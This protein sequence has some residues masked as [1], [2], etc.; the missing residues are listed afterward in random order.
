MPETSDEP[1]SD[2][3]VQK[4]KSWKLWTQE[5][6]EADSDEGD[7]W[8]DDVLPEM[9]TF[10]ASTNLQSGFQGT[11][12]IDFEGIAAMSH[13]G[14]GYTVTEED[15]ITSSYNVTTGETT[16]SLIQERSN[17]T[18]QQLVEN[19]TAVV[20]AKK[21]ELV[22][23]S[24]LGCFQRFPRNRARNLVDVRWV[25]TWKQDLKKEMQIKA[26]MT[27]R[28]FKDQAQGLETFAGTASRWG[29][30]VV[31]AVTAQEEE[32]TLF[33]FDVSLAFAKGLSFKELSEL[34]GE[35]L[36]VVQFELSR[37]DAKILQKIAGFEAF[38]AE[39]EVLLMVKAVYGLKDAPRA[40]RK[41]LHLLLSTFDLVSLY[42]D[43]QL[44]TRHEKNQLQMILSAHVDDLKGGAPKKLALKLLSH[45][46]A[47]IGT[48]KQQWEN[49][50]HVGIEHERVPE[51][52]WTHQTSYAM[53]LKEIDR[54]MFKSVGENDQVSDEASNAFSSLL[55]GVAWLCL[56][57]AAIAIYVQS[58]QRHGQAPRGCDM[59]RL[60]LVVR[61]VKKHKTGIMFKR[62]KGPLRLVVVSDAAFKSIPDES[63][64][65]ALRGAVII[66]CSSS[67][68]SP[69]SPD[70]TCCMIEYLCKRQRRVV[71]STFSGELNALIDAIELLLVLQI[72]FHQV[73]SGTTATA[74]D[75]AKLLDEGGLQPPCEAVIDARSVFD[76]LAAT[77]VGDLV[78]GSLKLHVLSIRERLATQALRCLWWSDTRD[79]LADGLTKGSVPRDQLL[80]CSNRG[81]YKVVHECAGT[82]CINGQKRTTGA[83]VVRN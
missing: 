50:M 76:C 78:E 18:K 68:T 81:E 28:G 31:N 61:W 71:R 69:A 82:R 43:P 37:E 65:L 29:Q 30:R 3:D 13:T 35:P 20:S 75:L 40:W 33:S 53:N 1:D 63:S 72:C 4:D 36:R 23:L 12:E 55:G 74:T 46:E 64:G 48:C 5:I 57:N 77:D 47:Q 21:S 39:K 52:I 38:N 45:L 56:S 60:N 49:F 59:K 34:T 10:L 41:K 51:G 22:S 27:V 54:D 73:W 44:Y 24:E 67:E 42:A 6:N 17:L 9:E 19:A 16:A 32:W 8:N 79:M 58:L 2:D 15:T 14:L 70:S 26:R 62:I 83:S 25:Y 80:A 11:I 66:L 7:E